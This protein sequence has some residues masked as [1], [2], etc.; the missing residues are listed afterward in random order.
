M[1]G[2]TKRVLASAAA[3]WLVLAAGVVGAQDTAD[4]EGEY[5][6][7]PPQGIDPEACG[8]GLSPIRSAAPV[9]VRGL[10]PGFR[11]L[12]VAREDFETHTDAEA[13]VDAATGQL[14]AGYVVAQPDGSERFGLH[15]L[16]TG[17]YVQLVRSDTGSA[18]PRPTTEDFG[19]SIRGVERRIGLKAELRPVSGGIPLFVDGSVETAGH[20]HLVESG[21]FG[22]FD[23]KQHWFPYICRSVDGGPTEDFF[24]A[25]VHDRAGRVVHDTCAAVRDQGADALLARPADR[26]SHLVTEEDRLL[27]LVRNHPVV[28]IDA[29]LDGR[30]VRVDGGVLVVATAVLAE[31]LRAHGEHEEWNTLSDEVISRHVLERACRAGP[32]P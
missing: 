14:L 10:A 22:A 29:G 20:R 7:P 30:D 28:V 9:P 2:I 23:K 24:L 5:I 27:T 16:H 31:L 13:Y 3:A 12:H 26:V 15:N 32:R 6:F 18:F 19:R 25:L 17:F 1:A 8:D 21:H 11:A 4:E